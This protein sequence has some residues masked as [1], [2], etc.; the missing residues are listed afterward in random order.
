MPSLFMPYHAKFKSYFMSSLCLLFGHFWDLTK[1]AIGFFST[2]LQWTHYT[3]TLKYIL[4]HYGLIIFCHTL[5]K[6]TYFLLTNII[7]HM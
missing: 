4:N 7:N 3:F 1:A 5:K 2:R 6:Y